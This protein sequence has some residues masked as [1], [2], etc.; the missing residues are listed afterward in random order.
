MFKIGQ[1]LY[2]LH[3]D[4]SGPMLDQPPAL[5]I[6][7]YEAVPQAFP[8]D[9]MTNELFVGTDKTIVYDVLM[10]GVL[11]VSVAENWLHAISDPLGRVKD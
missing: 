9:P 11:E 8:N 5:V 10:D 3:W 7:R 6:D 1:L 4:N 2:I